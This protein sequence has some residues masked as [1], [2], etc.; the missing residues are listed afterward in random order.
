MKTSLVRD[1]MTSPAV[2]ERPDMSVT[3]LVAV[4][5]LRG[6]SAVPIVDN[7][8]LVGLVSTTDILRAPPIARVRDIMSSPVVTVSGDDSLDVAAKRLTSA[9]VHR[10]VVLE[11]ERVVG[12]LSAR[13]L[14]GE[15]KERKVSDPLASAMTTPVAAIEV[16]EA[17]EEAIRQLAEANVHGLV[18]VDGGSPVG[19]FTHAEALAARK[20]PPEM[21]QRPVEDL[22]SYETVCLDV[23][24]PMYRAAAYATSMNVRRILV[25]EHRRLAGVVSCLDLVEVLTRTSASAAREPRPL[26][27][28]AAGGRQ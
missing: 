17:I 16:G 18:V 24:T 26:E 1:R 11:G 8:K 21:Q 27:P 15:V 25:V 12:V 19:V 20:L 3:A 9:R 22:M 14:L 23:S 13:D 4:L 2:T 7:G 5:R 6:I 28:A 10:V